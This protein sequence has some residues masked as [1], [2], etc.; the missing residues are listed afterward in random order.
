MGNA[1]TGQISSSKQTTKAAVIAAVL[2]IATGAGMGQAPVQPNTSQSVKRLVLVSIPDR[3]LAVIENGAVV[4]TYPVAVGRK[5][6]PSP[7]GKFQINSRL[8]NPTYYHPGKVI[9]PGAENPLGN[10]WIGLSQ[11]GY[12]IHG[13]NE[14]RSIGKAASHGCIRMAK[15]DLEEIFTI[16][17]VG[18]DVEIRG[19][20]DE[21]MAQVF[22]GVTTDK[23][24][25]A[26]AQ[27]GSLGGVQ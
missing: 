17:Q 9:G 16:V 13:T 19:E 7:T 14:P 1:M 8:V 3:K 6:S 4:K 12:G 27:T 23:N 21:Q 24:V 20:R 2:M 18:D 10:R 5:S 15:A 11:K 22:G 25:I 26:Q